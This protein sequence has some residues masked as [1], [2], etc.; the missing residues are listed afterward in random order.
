MRMSVATL[1]LNIRA[2]VA[3]GTIRGVTAGTA[4]LRR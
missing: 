3:R 4:R 1:M 2:A